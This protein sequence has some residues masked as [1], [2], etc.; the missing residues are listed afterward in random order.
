MFASKD[1]LFAGTVASV[2]AVN[3]SLR[4]RSSASAYLN[5][6][7]ATPTS[8]TIYTLS[9]WVKRGTLST[10]QNLFGA[11]TTTSLSFNS[12][13]QIVLTLAGT[14]AVTTTAVYRDP[15]SWYHIVYT[16]NGSAQTIY[17]NET[18]V[19]T[20]TTANTVFNTAIAHQ[21]AAANT[22]NYFDGYMAEIN[23]VDGQTLTPS[24]FGVT[25]PNS[26]WQPSQYAGS[27]GINGFYLKFASFGTVAALGNDSSGNGNTW[28]VNNCSITA[29]TTYDPMLDVPTLTS[30]TVSN[31]PVF[32][33]VSANSYTITAGNLNVSNGGSGKGTISSTVTVTTGKYYWEATGV[34]YVGAICGPTTINYTG[35]ISAT[36]SKSIGYWSGGLVYWDG[37]NSGAGPATYTTTDIIGVALDMTAG[38]VAFYKNNALQYTATFGS[39]TVPTFT[40]G[41]IPCYNDGVTA[42]TY[43][44]QI[45]FGQ[46]A[47]S[48]SPPSGFV[49]LNTYNIS[50][51]TVTTSGSFTG[52][53]LA[54]GPF[55]WLN[56]TP[57]A[58]TINSNA[59]TF[60][61]H[62]DK[63]ANGFK[64]R[65]SST[66]YNSTGT[67]T[68]SV[69]TTGA[70]FKY[71]IAQGNP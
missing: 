4:F 15:S 44:A 32:N 8:S 66:S 51:G 58:M 60:G 70:Q 12:S 14:A 69:S 43:T 57:T 30:A 25:G 34:G 17:V 10:T 52:N 7:F 6:T 53:A 9:M 63:L 41:A 21:L 45:N 28:T 55:I 13:D 18:S 54:N 23:F 24:S 65:T 16:Q 19:G 36:G 27:Y 59:V 31:Y 3:N 42:A 47:F 33:A 2:Y 38:T 1:A 56:G 71:Q 61:T 11:S 62:A 67:N 26:V 22:T 35:S 20:G 50:A 40:T 64:V 5:R 49:A 37:G 68:Y 48:Y 29:G 46:R 39:G